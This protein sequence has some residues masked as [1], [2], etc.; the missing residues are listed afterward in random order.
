M[1][2]KVALTT[3]GYS[4]EAVVSYKSAMNVKQA[5]DGLFDIFWVDINPQSWTCEKNGEKVPINKNDFSATINGEKIVFD[6]VY[7]CIH[8]TPGEDGKLQSYFEMLHIP[9]VACNSSVST[10]CFNKNYTKS[11]LKDKGVIIAKEVFLLREKPYDVEEIKKLGLPIFVKPNTAGSSL[12]ISKVKDWNELEAAIKKAFLEESN[13]VLIEEFIPGREFTIGV[14][15]NA[16]GVQ[17]LPITEIISHNEF[18]DFE[19]KYEGKSDEITPA[20]ISDTQRKILEK[21]AIQIYVYLQCQGLVRMEVIWHEQKQQ[22]YFLEVNT[23]PGFTA[24]SLV[25]QQIKHIGISQ[26]DFLHTI[27]Q[28]TLK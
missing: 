10:L 15:E 17:V 12:G 27:I 11:F 14:Y 8:G 23:I 4:N 2:K 6:F 5:L 3:G 20:D 22:P 1:K 13:E 16:Q 19:A 26:T 7:I 9:Y 28:Q 25:P 21:Y 24:A 18:F